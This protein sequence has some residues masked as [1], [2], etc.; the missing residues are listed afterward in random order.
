MQRMK[1]IHAM[2]KIYEDESEVILLVDASNAFNSVNRKTF[3]HNIGITR[4]PLAN[5]VQNYYNRPTG[6]FIIGEREIRS[7]EGKTQGDPTVKAIYAIAI[8]TLILMVVD[9]TH[10]DDS[11]TKTAAYVDDFTAA[12]KMNQLKK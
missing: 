6:L 4:P 7:N 3:L 1:I 10:Q 9:I 5:F 11:S 12:N 8:T 2:H